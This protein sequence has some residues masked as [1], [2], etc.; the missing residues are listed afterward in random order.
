MKKVV[1]AIIL[2]PYIAVESIWTLLFGTG[3]GSYQYYNFLLGIYEKFGFE[4]YV[5]YIV[6]YES[7]SVRCKRFYGIATTSHLDVYQDKRLQGRY[8]D[9]F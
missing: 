5:K 8:G 4:R 3:F 2:F 6:N 1:L 9:R 7:D